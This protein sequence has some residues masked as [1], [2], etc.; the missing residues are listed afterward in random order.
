MMLVLIGLSGSR[1]TAGSLL[2]NRAVEWGRGAPLQP[3]RFGL[4]YLAQP[5]PTIQIREAFSCRYAAEQGV[6]VGFFGRICGERGCH[7]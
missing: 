4:G 7:G 5:W 2:G 6:M 3:P 1:D